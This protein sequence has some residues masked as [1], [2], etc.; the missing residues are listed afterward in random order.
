ETGFEPNRKRLRKHTMPSRNIRT[1]LAAV[2]AL[3]LGGCTPDPSW[4]NWLVSRDGYHVVRGLAYGADPRQVLDVYV[5]DHG[6][7]KAPV[8]VF[9]YG[10]SWQFGRRDQYLAF[11]QAFA[12][13]GIVTV[14]ADYRLYPQVTYPAFVEDGAKA[15]A[16][17]H[18]HVA[19]YG[20]DPAR[21]FVSGHSA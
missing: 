16:Y 5:P 11:G 3:L 1:G 21:L 15:V 17:V 20:G 13:L 12:T 2:L 8:L 4:F 14:V 18:A 19:Q 7:A 10:G 6:A 9:F